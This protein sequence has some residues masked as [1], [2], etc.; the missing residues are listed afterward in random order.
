[1]KKALVGNASDPA[2]VS[3]AEEKAVFGR[4]R[5]LSDLRHVL[6]SPQGRRFV[7]RYLG[8][9]GVFTQRNCFEPN[10]TFYN[11]GRRSIGL[12]ILSEVTEAE[13][14]AYLT[15]AQEAKKEQDNA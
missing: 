3:A 12:Q 4:K 1:M 11:E 8:A 13:P 15:M 7:W 14:S 5:E 2:Q 9:C 10:Q 6:S